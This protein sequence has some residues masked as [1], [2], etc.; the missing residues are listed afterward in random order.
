MKPDKIKCN[1]RWTTRFWLR[2]MR[3]AWKYGLHGTAFYEWLT[4]RAVKSL[5]WGTKP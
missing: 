5:G 4:H 1:T 2:S 3:Y